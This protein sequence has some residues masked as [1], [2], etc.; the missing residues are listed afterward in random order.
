MPV[1]LVFWVHENQRQKTRRRRDHSLRYV[2]LNLTSPG[3]AQE[4]DSNNWEGRIV[5]A[6][7]ERNWQIQPLPSSC[8]LRHNSLSYTTEKLATLHLFVFVCDRAASLVKYYM[9][10]L[11][12]YLTS[13]PPISSVPWDY[14]P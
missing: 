1:L 12:L 9:F 6:P 3:A 7:V 11:H 14:I 5:N 8:V 13:F 4:A 10:S 2:V